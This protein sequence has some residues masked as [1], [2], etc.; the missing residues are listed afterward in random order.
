MVGPSLFVC[1]QGRL[2]YQNILVKIY[3]RVTYMWAAANTP[4]GPQTA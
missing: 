3:E 1:L 2:L 4:K